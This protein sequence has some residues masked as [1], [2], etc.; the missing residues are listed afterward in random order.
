M[1]MES[2]TEISGKLP[3][4]RVIRAITASVMAWVFL[5]LFFLYPAISYSLDEA[6]EYQSRFE[7]KR[8]FIRFYALWE[9]KFA[10]YYHHL[11][12]DEKK[13]KLSFY[14]DESTVCAEGQATKEGDLFVK[15]G[16]WRRYYEDGTLL[17]RINYRDDKLNGRATGYYQNGR[18]AITTSFKQDLQSGSCIRYDSTGKKLDTV[19]YEDDVPGEYNIHYVLV[20]SFQRPE[21]LPKGTFYDTER[22]LWIYRN[23]K[24]STLMMWTLNGH[25]FCEVT[26]KNIGEENEV[27]DGHAVFW[28]KNG[29]KASEGSYKNGLE[30]GSWMVW[31]EEGELIHTFFYKNGKIVQADSKEEAPE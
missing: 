30:S 22:E 9:K 23:M 4:S 11:S 1:K 26:A 21:N 18:L 29:Q 3:R 16:A 19:I 24:V 7:L 25:P 27:I 28:H 15:K 5:I 10:K 20:A 31:N 14:Y 17:A 6:Q 12:F 2:L 8:D 13:G